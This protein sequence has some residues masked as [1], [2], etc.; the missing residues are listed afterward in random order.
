M[1]KFAS[2]IVLASFVGMSL[3]SSC[4]SKYNKTKFKDPNEGSQKVYGDIGGEPLTVTTPS[5]A[6]P[7]VGE[8]SKEATPK[9]REEVEK[10]FQK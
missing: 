5:V 8:I 1:N 2:K 10:A 4:G 7:S 6:D 9:F 3:L